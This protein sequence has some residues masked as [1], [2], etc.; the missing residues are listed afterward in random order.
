MSAE[1]YI[2]RYQHK[3]CIRDSIRAMQ[4]I[5]VLKERTIQDYRSV[6]NDIREWL[7]REKDERDR[8]V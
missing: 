1:S 8:C 4:S 2:I 7:Y 6:Y 3:M 5:D